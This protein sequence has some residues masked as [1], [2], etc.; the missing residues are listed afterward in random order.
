MGAQRDYSRPSFFKV[1]FGNFKKKLKIPV[2]FIGKFKGMIP[3]DS[4][5]RSP[6]G[7]WNVKIREEE[8]GGLSFRK[9]W[10][11]FVEAHYLGHGDFVTMKY[12]G[13]SQFAVKL[14][15]MNG[16][17]K[18]LPSTSSNGVKSTPSRKRKEYG[19]TSKGKFTDY[20]SEADHHKYHAS[21]SG[22]YS[23][24][25][26]KRNGG[27]FKCDAPKRK[28][29]VNEGRTR[30]DQAECSRKGQ[31][32]FLVI[33]T[34][35]KKYQME[36][37]KKVVMKIGRTLSDI[38][39][40]KDAN[41]RIWNVELKRSEGKVWFYKGWKEFAEHHSLRDGYTL[42][43]SYNGNSQ[44]CVCVTNFMEHLE[45]S[46]NQGESNPKKR[47][48]LSKREEDDDVIW[49]DTPPSR[50]HVESKTNEEKPSLSVPAGLDIPMQLNKDKGK[51]SLVSDETSSP[52]LGNEKTPSGEC[53]PTLPVVKE[54]ESEETSDSPD[55]PKLFHKSS[56]RAEGNERVAEVTKL[57]K[58]QTQYPFFAVYMRASYLTNAYLHIPKSFSRK[59]LPK[60]IKNV[61][62]RSSDNKVWTLG[63]CIRGYATQFSNGWTSLR[64]HLG[65][66]AGDVIV[67]ELLTGKDKEMR[68]SIIREIDNVLTKI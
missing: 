22:R 20:G 59:H 27:L 60:T 2:N 53:P 34:E 54:E 13:D 49:E 25:S 12:I 29:T 32:Y 38:V 39:A 3:Y 48:R 21:N 31:P 4:I 14:Y 52:C 9:G 46:G 62:V 30:V 19:E 64:R 42:G 36:I 63:Y 56:R 43:I 41:G 11:D 16:C 33:W 24:C 5:L 28:S 18:V 26:D 66:T 35:N 50:T 1:M 65:L 40:L 37:P 67:F 7:S 45:D 61:M 10:L 23:F 15:G 55:A 58:S 6:L 51:K 68:V 17:E 57:F 47:C 44:F 8:N